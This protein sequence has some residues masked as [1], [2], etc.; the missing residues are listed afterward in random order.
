MS[1]SQYQGLNRQFFPVLGVNFPDFSVFQGKIH[2]FL[3]KMHFSATSDDMLA[4][5]LDNTGQLIG[6]YM[7]MRLPGDGGSGTV[8]NQFLQDFGYIAPFGAA[9]IKL[10]I[11]VGAGAAFAKTVIAVTIHNVFFV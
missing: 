7:R 10:S 5:V 1:C 3:A 9:G 4:N 11:A 8:V 6:S 2:H